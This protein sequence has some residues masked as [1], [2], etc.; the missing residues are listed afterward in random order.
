MGNWQDVNERKESHYDILKKNFG[1]RF[2]AVMP[3]MQQE[4][5]SIFET[6]LSI[7]NYL[8]TNFEKYFKAFISDKSM[9]RI[10]KNRKIPKY[11]KKVIY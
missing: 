1:Q 10:H 3:L 8:S 9:G 7:T 5:L 6:K 2:L 4:D 11:P